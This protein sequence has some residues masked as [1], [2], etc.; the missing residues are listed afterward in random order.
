MFYDPEAIVYTVTSSSLMSIVRISSALTSNVYPPEYAISTS[1]E[2]RYTFLLLT[3]RKLVEYS[4]MLRLHQPSHQPRIRARFG[5]ARIKG[6]FCTSSRATSMT[7]HNSQKSQR[8]SQAIMKLLKDDTPLPRCYFSHCTIPK[9]TDQ[10][11]P[12]TKQQPF[13]AF[14][15]YTPV[16]SVSTFITLK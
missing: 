15:R 7:L 12:P 1:L 2:C 4:N 10:A 5:L 6:V 16:H 14:L 9:Y 3:I 13:K 11:R 8:K